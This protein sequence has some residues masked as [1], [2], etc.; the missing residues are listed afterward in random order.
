M[1]EV[2]RDQ[3]QRRCP[4]GGK[5]ANPLTGCQQVG[6]PWNGKGRTPI[7]FGGK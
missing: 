7:G 1:I 6:I 5:A 2:K 4:G 3:L